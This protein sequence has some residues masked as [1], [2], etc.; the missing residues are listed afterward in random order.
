MEKKIKLSEVD[1]TG[2]SG[3]IAVAGVYP[4]DRS[5][6]RTPVNYTHA[7]E[8]AGG[9]PVVYSTFDRAPKEEEAG[10]LRMLT[11]LDP[12]K[13]R[14]SEEATG[15]VLPGGGDVNPERYG[16][17]PH[18]RTSNVS[19]RR[20]EFETNLLAQALERDIPILAICRGMQLLNVHLGGTLEQ[21]LAD[22]EGRLDHDRDRPRAEAAH[23]ARFVKGSFLAGVLGSHAD[24]NSHHHQG[25][26]EVSDDLTEIGWADDGVLEAVVAP[27]AYWVVGVQWH[28]EVM[29][30]LRRDELDIFRRFVA[31]TKSRK[32]ALAPTIRSA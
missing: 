22:T 32:A 4:K 20:D 30:P 11:A 25:L 1:T 2:A 19:D 7:I 9:D 13:A 28:P 10:D 14:L 17:K 15:L 31:A 6:P 16:Q 12:K 24:V 21:H 26:D 8:L 18:A 23:G 27:E 3:H 29:A 5:K